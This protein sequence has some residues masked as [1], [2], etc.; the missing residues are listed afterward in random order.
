MVSLLVEVDERREGRGRFCFVFHF[1]HLHMYEFTIFHELVDLRVNCVSTPCYFTQ[2]HT[3]V[4]ICSRIEQI[5]GKF[6]KHRT[7]C[8]QTF[9]FKMQKMKNEWEQNIFSGSMFVVIVVFFFVTS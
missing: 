1:H 4:H 8:Y 7:I 9:T 5:F 3:Y 6:A 2:M